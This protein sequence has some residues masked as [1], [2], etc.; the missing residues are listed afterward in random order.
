[1]FN[2]IHWIKGAVLLI[3]S[4]HAHREIVNQIL[5][6]WK[7]LLLLKFSVPW[8][9][10]VLSFKPF[11]QPLLWSRC[12]Y[13]K[14]F[15][16]GRDLRKAVACC[17]SK[18][19]ANHQDNRWKK[20]TK[21]FSSSHCCCIVMLNIEFVMIFFALISKLPDKKAQHFL[22]EAVVLLAKKTTWCVA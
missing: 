10:T 19:K 3:K 5:P 8:N 17:D 1:M 22:H 16:P 6:F 9:K 2:L 14:V 13:L 7:V 4:K 11:W 21:S 18:N 20:F 15:T 12:L